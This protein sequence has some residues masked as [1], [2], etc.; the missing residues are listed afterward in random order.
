MSRKE[1]FYSTLF[2]IFG[3]LWIMNG[4]IINFLQ[5]FCYFFIRPFNKHLYRKINYYLVYS[6]WS[7]VV[8]IAEY[9]CNCKL[10]VYWADE[11]TEKHFGREHCVSMLNH[12][13]ELDW[14][15]SWMI[16]E[17]LHCLG[18]SRLVFTNQL[19]TSRPSRHSKSDILQNYLS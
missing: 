15:Y 16:S 4:L 10:T 13:Y 17:K 6:S 19:F 14:L 11:E 12:K 8:A 18:V 5:A 2:T 3:I 7:Q 9:W 1:K